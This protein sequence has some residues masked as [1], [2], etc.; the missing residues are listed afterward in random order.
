MKAVQQPLFQPE[1]DWK[2]PKVSDLPSWQ[3]VKRIGL[4]IE[5]CDPQLK[6]LGP[7]VRR[8]GFIAGI[9]FAIED[10]PMHYVPIAHHGGDNVENP[11]Q[12]L[13][14]FQDLQVFGMEEAKIRAY[15]AE[16]E[17]Q[18]HEVHLPLRD[19]D[20]TN[21]DG[22]VRICMEHLTALLNIVRS[23]D[24]SKRCQGEVH[25]WIQNDGTLSEGEHFDFGMAFMFS[26]WHKGVKFVI[27]NGPLRKT[28]HK[29]FTNLLL[30]MAK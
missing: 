6:E 14:Y 18:G 27:A 13:Q 24:P 22:G 7:G 16:L 20:Q 30:E 17:Q 5:T 1:C 10:G 29:S 21:D 3:G 8:D 26:W 11:D 28:A 19:V 2:P 9:S 15:V 23:D 25:V 4:D 12:A